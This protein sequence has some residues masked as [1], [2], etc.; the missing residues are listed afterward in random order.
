MA[1]PSFERVHAAAWRLTC[2]PLAWAAIR[3]AMVLHP[4]RGRLEIAAGFG[5]GAS[6][7]NTIRDA[8]YWHA[9]YERLN[10]ATGLANELR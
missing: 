9:A 2:L 4:K 8:R 5:R 3:L 1:R 6:L 7:T 10:A